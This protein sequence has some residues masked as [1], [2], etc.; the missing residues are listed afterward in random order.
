MPMC[1][2]DPSQKNKEEEPIH[3]MTECVGLWKTRLDIFGRHDPQPPFRFSVFQIIAFLKEAN[4]P[5]FPMQPFLE[6]LSPTTPTW[7]PN[8]DPNLPLNPPLN[9]D[10]DPD[11]QPPGHNPRIT[12]SKP[13]HPATNQ[14]NKPPRAEELSN[15]THPKHQSTRK[16]ISGTTLTF[17]NQTH[18]RNHM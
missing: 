9:P 12:L 8:P 4:I 3:L 15:S 16:G 7:D 17:T 5:S 1:K 10:P 11:T 13:I 18:Y 6:E 2:F 14:Q